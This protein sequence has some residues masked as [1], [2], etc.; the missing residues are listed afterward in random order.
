MSQTKEQEK[1]TTA[2]ILLQESMCI[3]IETEDMFGLFWMCQI[4]HF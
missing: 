4:H 3:F 2:C 1:D